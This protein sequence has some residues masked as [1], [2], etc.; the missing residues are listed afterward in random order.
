MAIAHIWNH[1]KINILLS[2][3]QIYCSERTSIAFHGEIS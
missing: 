1:N 2:T 3:Y